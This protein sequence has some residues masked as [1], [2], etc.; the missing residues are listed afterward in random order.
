M[1]ETY[2]INARVDYAWGR[3]D[4]GVYISIGEAF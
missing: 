4:Q 1:I 3:Y 2:K